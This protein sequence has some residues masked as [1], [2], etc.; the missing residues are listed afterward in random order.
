MSYKLYTD[1]NENFECDVSVKNASLKDSFARLI[2]ESDDG[3][4]L[5]F[6][7]II[8]NGKCKIP[9]HRLKGILGEN[10]KGKISLELIVE[11][12][13]FKPWQS[14][15]T[16]E[17]H[18]SIKV[19]VNE[20]TVPQK[21]I[22]N[23]KIQ[24]DNEKDISKEIKNKNILLPV[25]ELSKICESFDINKSTLQSKKRDLY[26]IIKEYFIYNPEFIKNKSIIL[27]GLKC[28]LK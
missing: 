9:I 18:T 10:D 16:V 7:G 28:F 8:N 21:P 1:R 3:I 2:V 4:N 26:R 23:V 6:K 12:T 22:V 5:I 27:F 24:T 17:K 15:F 14:D 20:Q 19:K 13:Y 25:Y 11:D